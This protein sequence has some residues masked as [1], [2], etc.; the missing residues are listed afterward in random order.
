[1]RGEKSILPLTPDQPP[2]SKKAGPLRN[3]RRGPRE[4]FYCD[5]R[6]DERTP[7]PKRTRR[8]EPHHL[9]LDGASTV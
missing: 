4:Q 6:T 2:R 9:I 7:D 3:G 1:M 5:D 8:I